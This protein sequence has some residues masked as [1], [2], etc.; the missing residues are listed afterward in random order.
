M[1]VNRMAYLQILL[2]GLAILWALPRI[3]Q[4]APVSEAAA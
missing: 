1:W 4:D 2:M 3:P